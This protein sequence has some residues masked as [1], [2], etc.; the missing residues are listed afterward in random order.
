[1]KWHPEC[2]YM[3]ISKDYTVAD[4][5]KFHGHL[6]PNIVIGYRIGRYIGDNFCGDPFRL[7]AKIFCSGTTP[8]SCIADGVQ[9]G[10]GCTVGKRN[11]DIIVSDSVKCEFEADSKKIT[12]VPKKVNLPPVDE[13]YEQAI[14]KFAEELFEKDDSELFEVVKS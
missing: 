4:L 9:L 8:E 11:I 5:A 2:R 7:K 10:A 12:I 1:M 3:D 6:G 14:E 13:N